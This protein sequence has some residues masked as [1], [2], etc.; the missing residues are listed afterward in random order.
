MRLYNSF[1]QQ[2]DAWHAA[3]RG[4]PTASNFS[5]VVQPVTGAPS[6]QQ[7]SY[8][9]HLVAQILL[10]QDLHEELDTYWTQRGR[11]MEPE[12]VRHYCQTYDMAVNQVAFVTTDDGAIGCS[13]DRMLVGVNGLL[14]V[15][16]PSPAVHC[17]YLYEGP[18]KDYKC[19]LQGQLLICEADFVD[20]FSYHP[21]MPDCRIRVGRNEGFIRKLAEELQKFCALK[22]EILARLRTLGFYDRSEATMPT[23]VF[24]EE[25]T[26]YASHQ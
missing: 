13:P 11:D 7:N 15:K 5:K 19:Q 8:V 16:C 2:S 10:N 17:R 14:E 6:R 22:E 25:E 12:A 9:Y 4:I 26:R 23:G 3:R 24:A 20:F 1:D 21:A 18:D